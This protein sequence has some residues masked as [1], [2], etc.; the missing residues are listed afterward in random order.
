MDIT[1]KSIE[2]DD[3]FISVTRVES[4]FWLNY[5][6]YKSYAYFFLFVCIVTFAMP[7]CDRK[8]HLGRPWPRSSRL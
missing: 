7:L 2:S 3:F 4:F 6:H 5:K 1:K 8:W